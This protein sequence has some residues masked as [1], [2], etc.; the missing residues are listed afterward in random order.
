MWKNISAVGF[1]N[2]RSWSSHCR[3]MR[4]GRLFVFFHRPSKS[5]ASS[6]RKGRSIRPMLAEVE[7]Y[8]S[9]WDC[10]TPFRTTLQ[11]T[12]TQT[13]RQRRKKKGIPLAYFDVVV[14]GLFLK[15]VCRFLISARIEQ[16]DRRQMGF[17]AL[18]GSRKR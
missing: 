13:T 6:G 18:N 10:L 7:R 9:I 17:R 16:I 5:P 8:Q 12:L 2:V 1:T 14:A 3:L 11:P 4:F 15:D